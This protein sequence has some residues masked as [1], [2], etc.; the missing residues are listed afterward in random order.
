MDHD[1]ADQ[2]YADF[3]AYLEYAAGEMTFQRYVQSAMS[4]FTGTLAIAGHVSHAI[5]YF[6]FQ[7]L[8]SAKTILD[9]VDTS[10]L[11]APIKGTDIS[12]VHDQ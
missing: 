12:W 11:D 9:N 7:I 1:K 5:E 8:P 6:K 2:H 4:R 3:A 10:T